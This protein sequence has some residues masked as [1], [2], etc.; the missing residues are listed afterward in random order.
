MICF[1]WGQR[2]TRVDCS[3]SEYSVGSLF[4]SLFLKQARVEGPGS[5]W[6]EEGGAWIVVEGVN[7]ESED[8]KKLS[9]NQRWSPPHP[10]PPVRLVCITKAGQIIRKITSEY[11]ASQCL[12][13]QIN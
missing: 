8:G 5:R 13:L 2:S 7:N 6:K 10:P 9:S 3:S 1:L 4:K 11:I 12:L